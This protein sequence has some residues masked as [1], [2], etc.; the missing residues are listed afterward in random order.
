MPSAS[1]RLPHM[2][3]LACSADRGWFSITFGRSEKEPLRREL[4]NGNRFD[5]VV[6][7]VP[8]AALFV[9]RATAASEPLPFG[10]IVNQRHSLVDE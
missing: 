8:V 9:E 10:N 6:R 5:R 4:R 7:E 3:V 2:S 1:V